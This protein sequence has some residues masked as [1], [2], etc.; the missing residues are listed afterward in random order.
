M[1]YSSEL[2]E[3]PKLRDNALLET[4]G[5]RGTEIFVTPEMNASN[6]TCLKYL[7]PTFEQ[8]TLVCMPNYGFKLFLELFELFLAPFPACVSW[9]NLNCFLYA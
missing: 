5:G 2:H 1:D 9:D 7:F 3:V 4:L 6:A 8:H